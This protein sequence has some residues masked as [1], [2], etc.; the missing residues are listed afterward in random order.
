MDQK[1]VVGVGNIYASEALYRAGVKP[2]RPAG[3]LSRIECD[4][5]AGSCRDVLH[6][7]LRAG[8]TTIRDFRQAG[9]GEG[10]FALQLQ[11]Y[12]RGGQECLSCGHPLNQRVIGG[13]STFWCTRCQK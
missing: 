12:G 1:T 2:M 13:R 7:A 9:G 5:I 3:R 6:E 11:V 8:G 4:K 10:Y